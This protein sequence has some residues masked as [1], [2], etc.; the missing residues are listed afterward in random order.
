M[1]KPEYHDI[2]GRYYFNDAGTEDN[3]PGDYDGSDNEIDYVN[4]PHKWLYFGIF[5]LFYV[6][7][8]Y[9]RIS[10]R[11]D[12]DLNERIIENENNVNIQKILEKINKNKIS[13]DNIPDSDKICSICLEDFSEEKEIIILDCKHIYHNDC[14]IQWIYKDTSCPLCRSSSLV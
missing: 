1:D 10:F 2:Q 14:I 3:L 13:P 11:R 4:F 5:I 9:K 8:C 12:T 7:V 6:S